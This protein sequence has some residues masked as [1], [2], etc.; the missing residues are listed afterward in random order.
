M[1]PGRSANPSRHWPRRARRWRCSTRWWWAPISGTPLAA[2]T[3]P[4]RSIAL[5]TACAALFPCHRGLLRAVGAALHSVS[6]RAPPANDGSG[7]GRKF[8]CRPVKATRTELLCCRARCSPT[9]S[10]NWR[11][12]AASMNT[13]C[14]AA[15]PALTCAPHRFSQDASHCSGIRYGKRSHFRSGEIKRTCPNRFPAQLHPVVNFPLTGRDPLAMGTP[16]SGLYLSETKGLRFPARTSGQPR[17]GSQAPGARA[18]RTAQWG[19]RSGSVGEH[20]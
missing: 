3:A 10:G 20:C 4:A 8:A 2:T 13:T 11:H 6:S 19:F 16:L 9:W 12:A 1:W 7:G 15:S 18:T 14:G 5:A 17:R